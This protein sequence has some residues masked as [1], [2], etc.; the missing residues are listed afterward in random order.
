M[1]WCSLQTVSS[2]IRQSSNYFVSLVIGT[3]ADLVSM[4]DENRSIVKQGLSFLNQSSIQIKSI[5]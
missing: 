5:T 4:T 1:V 3:I 2:F